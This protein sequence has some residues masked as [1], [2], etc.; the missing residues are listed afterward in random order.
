MEHIL[1]NGAHSLQWSTFSA[2]EH[3]LDFLTFTVIFLVLLEEKHVVLA[4][5]SAWRCLAVLDGA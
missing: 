1:C 2:I 5:N 4:A 3:V